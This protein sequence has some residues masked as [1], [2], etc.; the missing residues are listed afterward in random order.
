MGERT[1]TFYTCDRCGRESEDSGFNDGNKCGSAT[2]TL[3]GSHG[4]KSY[5]GA[6][7]GSRY[8]ASKFLCFS[9]ADDFSAMLSDFMKSTPHPKEPTND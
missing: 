3:K 9:C 7:G 1:V 6:W 8:D 2:A 4:G 5:D